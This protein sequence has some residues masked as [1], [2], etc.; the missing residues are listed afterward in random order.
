M[1]PKNTILTVRDSVLALQV[2]RK[3][4]RI[5]TMLA[6]TFSPNF[7]FSHSTILFI[8]SVFWERLLP[9]CSDISLH[10]LVQDLLCTLSCWLPWQWWPT[11]GELR[12]RS[13]AGTDPCGLPCWEVLFVMMTLW[14]DWT[15]LLAMSLILL[16]WLSFGLHTCSLLLNF[17]KTYSSLPGGSSG[18]QVH[19]RGAP[20]VVSFIQTRHHSS[21]SHWLKW[22]PGILERFSLVMVTWTVA[23]VWDLVS[24]V[25]SLIVCANPC[26]ARRQSGN[27]TANESF[28]WF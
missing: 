10:R 19:L 15:G 18:F 3:E 12:C 23:A 11:S 21:H 2:F 14:W 24:P 27:T 4:L 16:M 22:G 26:K 25:S 8:P 1:T 20:A 7:F 13:S 28:S 9:K 5:L 6:W 17:D